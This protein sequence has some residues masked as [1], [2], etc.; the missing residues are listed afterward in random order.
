M[1]AANRPMRCIAGGGVAECWF[2][3]G[4]IH[5]P[6]YPSP[7]LACAVPVPARSWVLV[8]SYSLTATHEPDPSEACTSTGRQSYAFCCE[9]GQRLEHG[10]G[11]RENRPLVVSAST[12]S[13]PIQGAPAQRSGKGPGS[14]SGS[15]RLKGRYQLLQIASVREGRLPS[16]NSSPRLVLLSL[17]HALVDGSHEVALDTS[18]PFHCLPP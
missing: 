8:S 3:A 2:A 17:P 13:S 14:L 5:D 12:G 11:P 4:P 6:S 16:E 7:S 9:G 18:H 15:A 10:S 1:T